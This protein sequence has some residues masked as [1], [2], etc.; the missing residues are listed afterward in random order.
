MSRAA[1]RLAVISAD[2]SSTYSVGMTTQNSLLA[3]STTWIIRILIPVVAVPDP[4]V[5]PRM[6]ST[7]AEYTC[8][9]R[10]VLGM[11]YVSRLSFRILRE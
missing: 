7:M 9:I 4:A 5:M 2:R 1:V 10:M 11:R 3:A 8:P 6:A